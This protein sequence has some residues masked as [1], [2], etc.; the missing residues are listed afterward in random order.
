MKTS[1]L[2]VIV[3]AIIVIGAAIYFFPGLNPL[4]WGNSVSPSGQT[5]T[6]AGTK[7]TS[8][9]SKTGGTTGTPQ[10]NVTY[11]IV[12]GTASTNSSAVKFSSIIV[13]LSDSKT[14]AEKYKSNLSADG[15]Y[16]F[17]VNPGEYKMNISGASSIKLP[18]IFYVGAG[19]T[20]S[21][22]FSVK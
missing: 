5:A 12:R 2:I 13:I 18:T 22:N 19:D 11:G 6:D 16:S 14:G 3:A 9:G 8:N 1:L 20:F 17:N 10:G 4:N 21:L 7:T 15:S